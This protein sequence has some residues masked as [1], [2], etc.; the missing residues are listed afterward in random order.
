MRKS[1][2]V[3]GKKYGLHRNDV[4]ARSSRASGAITL[5]LGGVDANTIKLLRRWRSDEMI[6]Y[7]HISARQ[8]I[9]KH[10]ATM[11]SSANY[12]LLAPN[13]NNR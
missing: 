12:T 5:L 6:R 9:H 10:A 1:V 8:L 3:L 13:T 4:S 2:D 7:L 11:F